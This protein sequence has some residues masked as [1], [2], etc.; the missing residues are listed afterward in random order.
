MKRLL[1]SDSDLLTR[2]RR[3]SKHP[4][5]S[6]CHVVACQPV[7]YR[8]RVWGSVVT[9]PRGAETYPWAGGVSA[10]WRPSSVALAVVAAARQP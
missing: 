10:A 4:T 7:S 2:K 3:R 6:M 5:R 1:V 8:A 9:S